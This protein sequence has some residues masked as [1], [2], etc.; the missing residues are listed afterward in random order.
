MIC[1]QLGT[2][3]MVTP[4][5]K[6]YECGEM[7]WFACNNASYESIKAFRE[8]QYN[9]LIDKDNAEYYLTIVDC[10]I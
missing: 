5:G 1:L 6:W 7:G 10:H 8:M 3:A 4:D 2:Y 9:Y